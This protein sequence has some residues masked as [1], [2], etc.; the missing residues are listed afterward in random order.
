MEAPLP[1]LAQGATVWYTTADGKRLL[2]IVVKVHYDDPP[3]YY[4][5]S[6]D[7]NER[8]TVRE[9]LAPAGPQSRPA[10]AADHP[11]P[12]PP[13]H[14]AMRRL[15]SWLAAVALLLAG[16]LLVFPTSPWL[17]PPPWLPPPQLLPTWIHAGGERVTFTLA[18]PASRTRQVAVI[19]SWNDFSRPVPLQ[20]RPAAG[21]RRRL[22]PWETSF[23]LPC[24]SSFLFR[25][26]VDGQQHLASGQRATR[27]LPPTGFSGPS[28]SLSRT[29]VYAL[30]Y[31]ILR[32]LMRR[33]G[34]AA[35]HTVRAACSQLQP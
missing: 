30:P 26:E 8:S 10:A 35:F 23:Y 2:A 16:A 6:I 20:P 4:T 29:P 18:A 32:R 22:P 24:G 15:L 27:V 19:G 9:K 12:P 17:L 7:G 1:E 11:Q 33:R 21:R 34:R 5:I 28:M 13:S 25:Y 31:E 3:P 14:A